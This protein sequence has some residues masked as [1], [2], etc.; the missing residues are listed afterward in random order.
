MQKSGR[1]VGD[2]L[3]NDYSKLK[4]ALNQTLNPNDKHPVDRFVACIIASQLNSA[5][6]LKIVVGCSMQ[7]LFANIH[8][9]VLSRFAHT[10]VKQ[11][12]VCENNIYTSQLC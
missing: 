10:N 6:L 4:C 7:D 5:Y 12:F 1:D 11:H 3:K 9:V 2:V 8:L